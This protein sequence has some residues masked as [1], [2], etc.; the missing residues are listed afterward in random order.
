MRGR[1]IYDVNLGENR[2][3]LL[4]FRSFF[5]TIHCRRYEQQRTERRVRCERVGANFPVS[6]RCFRDGAAANRRFRIARNGADVVDLFRRDGV[7][8]AF[9]GRFRCDR[10]GADHFRIGPGLGARDL[11]APGAGRSRKF[12]VDAALSGA[13]AGGKQKLSSWITA[14]AV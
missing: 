11:R 1:T 3:N 5:Y 2:T 14:T 13:R 4:Y 8:S 10:V 6:F 7:G 12:R 9:T